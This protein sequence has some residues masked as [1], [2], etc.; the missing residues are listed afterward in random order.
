MSIKTIHVNIKGINPLLLNNPQTVDPMNEFTR[1]MKKITKKRAKTDEDYAQ[2]ADLE[3]AAKIYWENGNL[4]IPTNWVTASIHA[5]SHKQAKIAKKDSRSGLFTTCLMVP[6]QYKGKKNVKTPDDIIHN[7][8]FRHK[9]ILKQ[10]QVKIC[11]MAPIFHDWSF[12]LDLEYDDEIYDEHTLK[13]LIKY[14]AAYGGYG[15]FRPTFGRGEATVE[16]IDE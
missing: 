8:L 14:A 2:L 4:V 3:M 13:D 16:N 10:Q 9:M 1:K 5:I 12:E 15:D 7:S 6:L 11:K